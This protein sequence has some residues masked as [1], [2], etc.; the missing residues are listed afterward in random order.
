MVFVAVHANDNLQ[1][2]VSV[3]LACGLPKPLG[4]MCIMWNINFKWGK[5]KKNLNKHTA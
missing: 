3:S 4:Y 5:F 1:T 2:I